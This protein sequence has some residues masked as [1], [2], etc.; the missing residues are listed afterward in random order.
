MDAEYK[1]GFDKIRAMVAADCMTDYAL[2]KCATEQVSTSAVEILHRLQL[3]DEMRLVCLFEDSFPSGY[4]DT[5]HFLLPL[6][7][8]S[9]Y[10]LKDDLVKLRTSLETVRKILA[11]FD[12]S[13]KDLYP[14]LRAMASGVSYFPEISRR[15]DLILDKF[16]EIRDNASPDLTEIRRS[17]REK[18][19]SVSRRISAILRQ[20]QS[21]GIVDSDATAS[22][23][24][25]RVLIPVSSSN[26]NKLPGLVLDESASG[27]TSF[28]EPM[29]VVEL[30]NKIR[31]L[32]FEEQ[33][34]ILRILVE[35][36]DF[37]RPYLPDLIRISEYMV[38]IPLEADSLG[39]FSLKFTNA[40]GLKV[41]GL[42]IERCGGVS[43]DN[44]SLRGNSGTVLQRLNAEECAELNSVRPYDLI[45]L[46]YGLNVAS[47]STRTYGWY[48]VEMQHA[49]SRLRQ[50]FP[51]A[52]FLI[53]GVSDRA[54]NTGAGL[55][56]MAQH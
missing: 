55:E 29:E 46:E 5:K 12:K 37:L 18:E 48:S 39:D 32:H 25:G 27:K 34:E 11:F 6:Q 10:M 3:T 30:N 44:F 31:E 54:H 16:G 40:L 49:V 26:K 41:L 38:S 4:V 24:D 22:V 33:R 43:V 50:N 19:G 28:I 15:I 35:F 47:D 9:A 53:L 42:T 17:I 36:S 14:K 45:I 21:D 20:A 1:I 2:D 51:D 8:P 13:E 52:D 23:H 56:T 7:A